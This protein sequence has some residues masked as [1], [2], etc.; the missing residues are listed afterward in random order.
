MGHLVASNTFLIA[1]CQ[2]T[3]KIIANTLDEESIANFN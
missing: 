1:I 3:H 2:A